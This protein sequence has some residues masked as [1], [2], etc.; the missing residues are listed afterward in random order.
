VTRPGPPGP[1]LFALVALGGALGGTLR[2]TLGELLPDGP[3][4]AF[5]TFAINVVGSFAL[6]LLPLAFLAPGPWGVLARMPGFAA[7]LGPGLLGGFTTLSAYSLTTRDLLAQGRPLLAA[8]YSLGTV[9][10]A[11]AGVEL[12]RRWERHATARARLS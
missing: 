2:W 9:V 10:A 1:S 7:L 12:A 6:A 3:G 4:F 8:A 11:L 5:T